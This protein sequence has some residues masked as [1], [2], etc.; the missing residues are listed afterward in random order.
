MIFGGV[1]FFFLRPGSRTYLPPP[2]PGFSGWCP[3]V[4]S[5][6]QLALQKHLGL[7]TLPYWPPQGLPQCSEFLIAFHR[8][9]L[10]MFSCEAILYEKSPRELQ[11]QDKY[12]ELCWT[13]SLALLSST[14]RFVPM[15]HIYLFRSFSPCSLISIYHL[16]L[17]CLISALLSTGYG[18][19]R[20]AIDDFS[21]QPPL[22]LQPPSS[23]NQLELYLFLSLSDF[24][25]F[26][27]YLHLMSTLVLA[28]KSCALPFYIQIDTNG[29]CACIVGI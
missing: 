14:S 7:Y 9:L 29:L 2:G 4:L 19:C 12:C 28:Q 26:I 18:P 13:C 17:S 10:D 16:H 25:V 22:L 23:Q 24:E 1:Q 8:N 11:L 6:L 5:S 20:N 21:C 27:P 15:T 3:L